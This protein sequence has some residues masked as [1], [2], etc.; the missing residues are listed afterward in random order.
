MRSYYTR[1][2]VGDASVPTAHLSDASV[3]Y[4]VPGDDLPSYT[5]D[6]EEPQYVTSR[7]RAPQMYQPEPN[8]QAAQDADPTGAHVGPGRP[9]RRRQYD[10]LYPAGYNL[11]VDSMKPSP[12]QVQNS[13][14]APAILPS[15]A[16][17]RAFAGLNGTDPARAPEL[18][19]WMYNRPYGQWSADHDPAI[20]KIEQLPP[21]AAT[22]YVQHDPTEHLVPNPGGDGI[23][24]NS[25]ATA[26]SH[27]NTYRP[28]PRPWDERLTV[29]DPEAADTS[30][31]MA[32]SRWRL[33]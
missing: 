22:P 21:L 23:T 5:A 7:Y 27:P 32:G 4:D 10:A 8:A 3:N 17:P 31:P 20:V 11:P 33:R 30:A 13:R 29:S 25:N 14:S 6:G 1:D 26:G 15:T 24:A 18:P 12:E 2:Q 28:V 9:D 19:L 16:P